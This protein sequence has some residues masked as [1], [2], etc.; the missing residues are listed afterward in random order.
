MSIFHI[1]EFLNLD[2]EEA[3]DEYEALQVL[4]QLTRVGLVSRNALLDLVEVSSDGVDVKSDRVLC[5]WHGSLLVVTRCHVGYSFFLQHREFFTSNTFCQGVHS[6][7][8]LEKKVVLKACISSPASGELPCISFRCM[9]DGYCRLTGE[10][11]EEDL[12]SLGTTDSR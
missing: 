1:R 4:K 8:S 10:C 12:I 2:L 6:E 9:E 3:D 7:A 11:L 5:N